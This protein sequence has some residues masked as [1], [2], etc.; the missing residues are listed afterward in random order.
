MKIG[1]IPVNIGGPNVVETMIS[2]SKKA[3]EVGLE[4]VWTF[5]HVMVPENYESK[6]PY[7][8]SGKMGASPETCFL[9]PFIAL[10]HVAAHTKKINL[11]TGVNIMTQA[12]PLYFAKQAASLDQVSAGRLL[13]GVGA[14]WLKEEF[15]ALGV[16]FER[17]GKRFDDYLEAVKKIWSGEMVE[18]KSKFIQWSGFKSYPLPAQKPHMPLI[19]GGATPPALRRVVAHGDGWFAPS[20]GDSLGQLIGQL[21]EVADKAGRAMDSIEISSMWMFASE[22]ADSLSQYEDMGVSRVLVPLSAWGGTDPMDGLEKL[23][24]VAASKS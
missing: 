17:R 18:H 22:G 5:E 8:K 9:D 20:F 4:S 15:E 10:A 16:P 23:G 11:G 24:N 2:F 1:I 7:D 19:I 13:L 21:K 3:E 6:Y 14:G 12:N